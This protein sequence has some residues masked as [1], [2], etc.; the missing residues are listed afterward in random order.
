MLKTTTPWCSGVSSVILPKCAFTTWFPYKNGI[1]PFGLI[2]IWR[3]QSYPTNSRYRDVL[4][5]LH[6]ARHSPKQWCAAW[7][8]HFCWICQNMCQDWQDS[9]E[10]RRFLSALKLLKHN[11]HDPSA[12]GNNMAHLDGQ[13]GER[14]SFP[15]CLGWAFSC[16]EKEGKLAM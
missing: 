7:T 1:S 10:R 2:H 4:C 9:I 16:T 8:C 6:I 5:T 15:K 14:D 3:S 13:W 11:R 12:A